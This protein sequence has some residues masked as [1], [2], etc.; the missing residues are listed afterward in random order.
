MCSIRQNGLCCPSYPRPGK[1]LGIG[2]APGQ[3]EVG[4]APFVGTAGKYLWKIM[5]EFKLVRN[6]FALI[7]TIQCR[8]IRRNSNG[9][10]T[11]EQ[12]ERCSV[13]VNKFIEI[14]KP[15]KIIIFGAYAKFGY[16]DG[17]MK[18]VIKANGRTRIING[19]PSVLSVHPALCIYMR[20]E[21]KELLRNAIKIFNQL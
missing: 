13:Y 6:D 3:D 7:N 18:G 19:V 21:G 4:N 15:K 17:S 2:E 20:E 8:P 10:P 11:L 16:F 14:V 9:K 12:M 1:Y 5:R